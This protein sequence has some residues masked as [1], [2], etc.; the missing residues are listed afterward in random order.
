MSRRNRV[1]AAIIAATALALSGCGGGGGNSAD[2]AKVKQT[3]TRV[4]GGLG[5]GDAATVCSS[6]TTAG[7]AALAKALPNSTC[8]KVVTLVSDHLSA[9]QKTALK[10][11]RIGKVEVHGDR[12]T[13]PNTSISSTK[14]S[15]RGFLRAG[16]APTRLTKGSDGTWKISG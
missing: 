4:L 9:G 2:I 12:A 10:S 5:S 16:S 8:T 6:A 3:I 11:V 15:L 1:I 7:Q 14:G 13:V